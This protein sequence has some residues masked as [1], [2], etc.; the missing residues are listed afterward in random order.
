MWPSCVAQGLI[1]LCL[2]SFLFP[3]V[4][5]M[6]YLEGHIWRFSDYHSDDLAVQIC[7]L[8]PGAE[9]LALDDLQG[10]SSSKILSVCLH[11]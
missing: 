6:D 8:S 7:F 10:F 4:N 3:T 9:G 5:A 2:M 1:H 11:G